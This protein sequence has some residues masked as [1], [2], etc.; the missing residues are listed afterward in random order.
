MGLLQ[1][2]HLRKKSENDE[3]PYS[4]RLEQD[5][6]H[7]IVGAD[8][9]ERRRKIGDLAAVMNKFYQ[10]KMKKQK[11]Q[12]EAKK[13]QEKETLQ[14]LLQDA[15]LEESE[16]P[17]SLNAEP[18]KLGS[19]V[20]DEEREQRGTSVDAAMEILYRDA[21]PWNRG[22]AEKIMPFALLFREYRTDPDFLDDLLVCNQVITAESFTDQ[23][24]TPL[25]PAFVK[26]EGKI[27]E[28]VIVKGR[29]KGYDEET[30][31]D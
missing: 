19:L 20:T 6:I 1:K 14:K 9:S 4:D 2:L 30:I 27:T 21:V 26:R 29:E 3:N 15:G 10:V 18:Q 12:S 7:R 23:D 28:R 22:E 17:I 24:V 25:R 8:I 16:F 31:E 11:Q 5:G 13:K